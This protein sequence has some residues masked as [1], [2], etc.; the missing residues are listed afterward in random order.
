[1]I[2][3]SEPTSPPLHGYRG[4]PSPEP[5]AI[6][7]RGLTV[8]VSREAGARGGSIA[9]RVGRLLGWP[10]YDQESLALLARDESARRELLA[11]VPAATAAWADAQPDAGDLG[12][13][14]FALAARGEVVIVGRGAGVVLPGESTLSVRVIA[15]HAER[16]AYLAQ[17]LRLSAEEAAAELAARDRMRA[18]LHAALSGK[19]ASDPTQYDLV[20]NS[21]RLGEAGCAELIVSAVKAKH[22][23]EPPEEPTFDAV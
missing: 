8:A 5:T 14:V 18:A 6:R 9:R 10:V 3:L 22:L 1:M 7:P 2:A 23:F 4:S 12:K 21:G 15:P 20:L 13:V 11:D 17:W 19:A 16:V